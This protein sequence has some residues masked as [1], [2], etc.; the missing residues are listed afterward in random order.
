MWKKADNKKKSLAAGLNFYKLF[1]IFVIF[2][3]YGY[4]F[5]S[6]A[7]GIRFGHNFDMQGVL[8]GPF[9]QIYGFGAV[10]TIMINNKIHKKSFAF[11]FVFYCIAGTVY[12]YL[13]SLLQEIVLGSVSWDYSFMRFNIHGRINI[14]YSFIWGLIGIIVVK[15]LY[16][17]TSRI[18][19]RMPNKQGIIITCFVFVFMV[20]NIIVSAAAFKRTSERYWNIPPSSE[21]EI[22]IDEK[23]ND[24]YMKSKFPTLIIK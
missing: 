12:E 9:S 7:D 22:Y 6:L 1:W 5:E 23:Y 15:F 13:C 3:F 19:E 8:Y 16:P 21:F 10:L 14:I 4:V 2:S 24:L 18:I 11:L 17:L 20:C